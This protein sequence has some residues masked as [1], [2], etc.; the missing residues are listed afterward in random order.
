MMEAFVWRFKLFFVVNVSVVEGDVHI[1]FVQSVGEADQS[2]NG[3]S[4]SN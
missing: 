1:F 2:V 3:C 4:D